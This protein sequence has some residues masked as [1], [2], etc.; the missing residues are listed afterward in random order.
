MFP[1]ILERNNYQHTA[2]VHLP[3]IMISFIRD[4]SMSS[5][6]QQYDH[7]TPD[8]GFFHNIRSTVQTPL[9]Y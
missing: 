1:G 3:L 5:V 4:T 6:T 2:A 8:R 7:D 9:R